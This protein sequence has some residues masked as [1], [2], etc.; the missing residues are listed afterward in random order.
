MCQGL[1]CR[2]GQVLAAEHVVDDGEQL[3]APQWTQTGG[4]LLHINNDAEEGLDLCKRT[5]RRQLVLVDCQTDG[6]DSC[7]GGGDV[8]QLELW[9]RD[10][11]E[12]V[13]VVE[14]SQV[15]RLQTAVEQGTD[16]G[17]YLG[18]LLHA[19]GVTGVDE[20]LCRAVGVVYLVCC[21]P[22]VCR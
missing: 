9:G 6:L 8:L 20:D 2:R 4:H 12:V 5:F 1:D 15:L 13:R 22:S 10:A 17:P 11:H 7:N 19:E 3:G 18:G 16:D 21:H 14:H